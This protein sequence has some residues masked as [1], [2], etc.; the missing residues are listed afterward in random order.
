MTQNLV[1]LGICAGI[2]G[3]FPTGIVPS[4]L[5]WIREIHPDDTERQNIVRSQNTIIFAVFL[6]LSEAAYSAVFSYSGENYALLFE[7][8]SGAFI[9]A[10]LSGVLTSLSQ[11][12]KIAAIC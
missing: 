11:S 6:A 1:M 12:R 10:F 9:L 5:E 2:I 3:S 7:I 8:S 4:V